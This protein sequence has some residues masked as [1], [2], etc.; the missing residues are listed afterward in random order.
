MTKFN[1]R[2]QGILDYVKKN[3]PD[4][5]EDVLL[6]M[7]R[8]YSSSHNEYTDAL[9]LLMIFAFEAGR[10]FQKDTCAELDNPAVYL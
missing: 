9:M 5:Y 4:S 1:K 3:R 8:A 6:V 2:D 7:E 10:V